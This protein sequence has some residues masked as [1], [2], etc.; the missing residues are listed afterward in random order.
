MFDICPSHE[1][2]TVKRAGM[3]RLIWE[4]LTM[5]ATVIALLAAAGF[6]VAHPATAQAATAAKAIDIMPIASTKSDPKASSAKTATDT[7]NPAKQKS[8]R[9]KKKAAP[10]D[11]AAK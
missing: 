9:P 7:T 4:T 10:A 11:G 6:A 1:C 2:G 3:I 5:R 8:K